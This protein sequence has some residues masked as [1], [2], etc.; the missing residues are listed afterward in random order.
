MTS[1]MDL[2]FIAFAS[3]LNLH[4]FDFYMI[5]LGNV[6]LNEICFKTAIQFRDFL[7]NFKSFSNIYAYIFFS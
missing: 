5:K 6:L 1:A 7:R 4:N 3:L 2:T